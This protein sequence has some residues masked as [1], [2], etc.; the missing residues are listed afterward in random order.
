[1]SLVRQI[2]VSADNPRHQEIEARALQQQAKLQG[3]SNT[4]GLWDGFVPVQRFSQAQQDAT[5]Q[6]DAAAKT[7]AAFQNF[8]V[9]AEQATDQQLDLKLQQKLEQ[10]SL[11]ILDLQQQ[12]AT[13]GVNKLDEQ[14]KAIDDQRAALGVDQGLSPFKAIVDGLSSG[15]GAGMGLITTL[16]HSSAQSEELAHQRQIAEIERAIGTNQEVIVGLEQTMSQQRLAYYAEKLAF[17][18]GKGLNADL[19]YT[20]ADL[21][22]KRAERQLEA[23]IFLAYLYERALAFFLGNPNIRFIAFD[24]QDRPG[25]ILDAADALKEDFQHV[26]QE[27]DQADQAKFDFFEQAVSLRESYPLQFARF[28]QTGRMT[29]EYSLYELSKLRPATHQCR[30]REVGVEVKGLVPVTGFSGTLTHRGRFLVRDRTATLTDPTATRLIPTEAQLA[31]ALD[32]QRRLGLPVAAV[33][34]VLVYNLDPD[35]KEL[36]QDTQFVSHTPPDQNTLHVFEGHGPTGLWQLEL[37]DIDN[38]G[39]SDVV[40]HLAI[41]SRESDIDVLGPKITELVRQYETE[42]TG[43]QA[44]DRISAYSLRQDF[45]DTYF[46]LQTGPSDFDIGPSNLPGA[47]TARFKQ[48]LFQ[49]LDNHGKGVPGVGLEISRQDADFDLVRVTRDDGFSEDLDAITAPPQQSFAVAGTW[50]IRLPDQSR[51]ADLGDLR[52]F[53]VHTADV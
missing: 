29:F 12:S 13:L 2:G 1:M 39:I 47:L 16:M 27:R 24:Y 17:L 20:L 31:A 38:L 11:Q 43:N 32:E 26:L 22:E 18:T 46:A 40:L 19:L 42:L 9:Q 7:A 35:T 52:L 37:R 48:L 41:V 14:L 15:L 51:F 5:L 50:Q 34:G 44:L 8:L 21:Q 3:R 33:G 4:L 23:A 28:P 25:G 30:L 6:I 53:V 36:S 49:A 45:P 10:T